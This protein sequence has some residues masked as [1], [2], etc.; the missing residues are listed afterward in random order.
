MAITL[1][2]SGTTAHLSDRLDWTDEY[3]WS[4]VQQAAEYSTTGALLVDIAVKQAGRP[5]T[6]LGSETAAWISRALCNTMAAWAALPGV[7]F[8]LVVRGQTRTVLFD[9]A[10]GGFD[11][12]P[13]WKLQ[14]GEQ[15]PEQLYLPTYRFIQ[16]SE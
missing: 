9:H 8:D 13:V 14:D 6:L 16:V 4:P 2:Y 7:E 15:S 1:T 3:T 12:E 5:I 10:K 11:A